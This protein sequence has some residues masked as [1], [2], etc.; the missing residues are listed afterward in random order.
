VFPARRLTELDEQ[1]LQREAF[2]RDAIQNPVPRRHILV[3]ETAGVVAGFVSAGPSDDDDALGELYAIYVLPEQWGRGGGEQLMTEA[4]A[5]LRRGGFDHAVLWVLED[6]PRA[7]AFYERR[8][9]FLDGAVREGTHLDT[10][11][12]EVRYR[13]ALSALS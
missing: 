12:R 4:I 2:W 8:G 5:R 6:N 3:F 1:R 7:R 11:T 10:R 9:W 13:V